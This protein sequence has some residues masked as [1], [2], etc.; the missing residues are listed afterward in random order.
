MA[1]YVNVALFGTSLTDGSRWAATITNRYTPRLLVL[2]SRVSI[3]LWCVKFGWAC[4]ATA[5]AAAFLVAHPA[6]D[7][8]G[9]PFSSDTGVSSIYTPLAAVFLL[10]YLLVSTLLA[11]LELT[12][13]SGVQNWCLD[14]KQNCV[15]QYLSDETD[16]N[17]WM[18]AISEVRRHQS[19]S[20]STN[21]FSSSLSALLLAQSLTHLP[22]P[23]PFLRHNRTNCSPTYT[24]TCSTR[25]RRTRRRC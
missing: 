1:G 5:V 23:L 12:M 14:Y 19:I 9:S 11:V 7:K 16:I 8:T 25:S 18:M 13:S 2:Q 22:F 21:H 3:L 20:H 17:T 6:Y 10:T 24:S 15:D 4:A